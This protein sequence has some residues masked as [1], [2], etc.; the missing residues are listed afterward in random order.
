MRIGIV[1]AGAMGR[2]LGSFLRQGGC[3]VV[4]ACRREEQV[5]AFRQSGVAFYDRE[6]KLQRVDVEAVLG[7]DGLT[8]VD[9]VL[10][11]VK[12]Y[13]TPAVARALAGKLRV[14]V[15][16][17]Q[18]GLGNGE[19]LAEHLP[20]ELLALGVTTYGATASG[21]TEVFFRGEGVTVIG[22]WGAGAFESA[23]FWEE[24][25]GS[26]GHHVRGVVDVKAEV[27]RKAMVNVG[28]NPFTALLGLRNGELLER[29]DLLAVIRETVEEAERV[30]L[31]EGVRLEGSFERVVE[32]CRMTAANRSSM[33][34][35]VLAGRKTEIEA[36]CGEI[37]RLG[38]KHGVATPRNEMLAA[39]VRGR[40]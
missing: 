3:R 22:P 40:S 33:L 11:T 10:V 5:Q 1:G 28:I 32:V 34:Q 19:V 20:E 14:P 8:R 27:W 31:L 18:N 6:E 17:L 29:E 12:S 21:E 15:L 4:M 24:L 37:V 16:S 26:C 9:G 30:A 38:R 35:D 7:V 2:L 13:D 36:L 23:V 39:L 25:L